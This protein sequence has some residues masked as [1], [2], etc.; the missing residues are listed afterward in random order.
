MKTEIF[1][2]L[3]SCVRLSTFDLIKG[4]L[5][6]PL[7]DKKTGLKTLGNALISLIDKFM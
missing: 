5:G 3:T 1:T 2:T 6:I 7:G 4:N